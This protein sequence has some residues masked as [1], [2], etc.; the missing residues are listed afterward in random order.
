MPLTKETVQARLR[1]P[2]PAELQ[3]LAGKIHHPLLPPVKL[4][5]GQGLTPDSAAIIAVLLN[6]DLRTARDKM[7]LANS[8]VLAA[9][10]LPNP[11][12]SFGLEKPTGGD[13]KGRVDAFGLGLS[14]DVSTLLSH[15][16][17][18]KR[19]SFNRRAVRLDIAWQEWQVALAAKDAVYQLVSLRKQL[20]LAGQLYLHT[21]KRLEKTREA[22]AEGMITQDGLIEAA[23]ADSRARKTLLDL[24]KEER[25]Q[26]LQLHR[27]LGLPSDSR[28]VL[29]KDIRLPTRSDLP[30]RSRM[31]EGLEQ[32]RLD[33]LA[34]HRGYEAE[35]ASVRAKI[36][37]QFPKI[38]L[39]PTFNRDTDN[40]R[41]TGFSLA[42]RLPLFNRNQGNI[43]LERATRQRL[44]DEY[45]N[46]VYEAD[47]DIDL[48]IA[49]IRF[50]NKQIAA[51]QTAEAQLARLEKTY[52]VALAQGRIEARAY[53]S[54]DY[55][56]ISARIQTVSL[57]GQLAKDLIGLELATG[58][59]RIPVPDASPDTAHAAPKNKVNP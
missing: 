8:Q 40:I 30:F 34:L 21:S 56:L 29:S 25:Q 32:R 5:P 28:I 10:L 4:E 35:E 42:V 13:T 38:S 1:P 19:A 3:I 23:K 54:I 43:A 11:E 55:D 36:M 41:T 20:A 22:L 52:G 53:D 39:G 17:Q 14:W 58:E 37:D 27:L 48:L 12:L 44:F 6:P 45:V 18:K 59:Y 24:K 15:A 2:S 51:A 50:T 49:G 7:A 31:V 46:R 47:S 57:E 26:H 9:S 16:L 33:L